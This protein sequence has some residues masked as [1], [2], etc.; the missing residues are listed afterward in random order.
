[1]SGNRRYILDTNAIISFL[2][3]NLELAKLL[4][5]ADYVGISII[6]YFEFLV[7]DSLAEKDRACFYEFCEKVEVVPLNNENKQLVTHV[8]NFRKHRLKLPDAIIAATAITRNAV[9]IT[10]DSHFVT[11]P[12]LIIQNC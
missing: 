8:M 12:A 4:D 3:G 11:A 5:S 2:S 10:N 7:F 9:L 1:M 6:S